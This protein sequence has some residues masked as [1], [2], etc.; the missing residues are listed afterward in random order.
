[1]QPQE[2]GVVAE[3]ERRAIAKALNAI[4]R[5]TGHPFTMRDE[6]GRFRIQKAVYLLKWMKYPPAQRFDYNLYLKGPYSPNLTAWYYEMQDQGMRSAGEAAGLGDP[7]RR[8]VVAAL[9][10]DDSF[11]EG[12]TTLL[13]VSTETPHLPA[14]LARA[15]AIK[16]HIADQ[17]WKEVLRFLAI[18]R[19][20][21]AVTSTPPSSSP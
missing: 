21:I 11:L 12:L 6:P 7:A 8:V 4:A 10:H 16:S 20:V 5:V 2:Q 15:K 9:G 14:A 1:M 3:P 19:S 18:N 13:D 17:T